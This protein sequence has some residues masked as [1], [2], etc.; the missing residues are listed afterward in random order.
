MSISWEGEAMNLAEMENVKIHVGCGGA[1]IN[2]FINID[3]RQTVATDLVLDLNLPIPFK[4]IECAFSNAFFEHLYRDKRVTHLTDLYNKLTTTGFICYIG[5]PYFK[6]VARFYLENM[7]G[8]AGPVFDL[9]NVY[10]Y[11]HGGDTEDVLFDNYHAQLHKSLFD[12]QELMQL[13]SKAGFTNY[14]IFCYGFPGDYVELPVT[15]G[16]FAMKQQDHQDFTRQVCRNFLKNFDGTYLRM[17]TLQFLS[18]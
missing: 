11:T 2:G 16:F 12:E 7:P 1:K 17:K 10:R 9:Y 13:L 14:V 4:S 18:V 3:V 8:T 6:N 15:M 5:I